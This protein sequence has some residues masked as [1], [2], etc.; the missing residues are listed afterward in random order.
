MP[1]CPASSATADYAAAVFPF[2][3]ARLRH[4]LAEMKTGGRLER[5]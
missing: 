4:W 3:F 2:G 5:V 1:Y